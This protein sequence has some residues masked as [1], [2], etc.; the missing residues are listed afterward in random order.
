M[1]CDGL[2]KSIAYLIHSNSITRGDGT[3]RMMGGFVTDLCTLV[4]YGTDRMMG[5]FVTDLCTL[6]FTVGILAMRVDFTTTSADKV[7]HVRDIG[8][9]YGGSIVHHAHYLRQTMSYP[10]VPWP[11]QKQ[12]GLSEY[13]TSRKMPFP[14]HASTL[15]SVFEC[16][17]QLHRDATQTI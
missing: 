11:K 10:P 1:P 17:A 7:K 5:G 2:L 12:T 16:I 8:I 6:V 3:D 15:S 14:K 4:F 9:K 13:E